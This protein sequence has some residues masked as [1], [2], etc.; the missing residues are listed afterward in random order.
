M[1]VVTVL[2]PTN[3]LEHFR[4][5]LAAAVASSG[6]STNARFSFV[7]LFDDGRLKKGFVGDVTRGEVGR[8]ERLE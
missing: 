3:T 7:L 4:F 2:P 8:D 5:A 1:Y 6:S